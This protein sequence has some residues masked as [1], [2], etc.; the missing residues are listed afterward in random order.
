MISR[1]IDWMKYGLAMALWHA[2]W[3]L[4]G[5]QARLWIV[6]AAWLLWGRSNDEMVA[7]KSESCAYLWAKPEAEDWLRPVPGRHD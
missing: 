1:A 6:T 7:W 2:G 5:C 3:S 4:P